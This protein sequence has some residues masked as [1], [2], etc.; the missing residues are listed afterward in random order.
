M[1]SMT[2]IELHAVRDALRRRLA[3]LDR[4]EDTCAHCEHFAHAPRCAKFDAEPPVDFRN[5]PGAC[6]E[7]QHDGVPF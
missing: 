7:W 4:I 2:S 1:T 5:T 3:E 6:E